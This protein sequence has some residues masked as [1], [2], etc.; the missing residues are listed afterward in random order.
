MTRLV[1]TVLSIAVL[2]AFAAT[3]AMIDPASS[4]AVTMQG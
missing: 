4:A 1:L 3:V 2:A